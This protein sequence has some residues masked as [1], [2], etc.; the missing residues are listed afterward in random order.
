MNTFSSDTNQALAVYLLGLADDKLV[1]GHRNGE[2]TGLGPFLEA[3]IAF[4]NIAQDEVAHAQEVYRLVADLTEPDADRTVAA[5][6]LAYDRSSQQ[7]YCANILVKSDDFDWATA[8]CRQ[9]MFDHF[10]HVRLPALADSTYQPLAGLAAKMLQEVTFHIEHFDDWVVRLG[11][12]ND[13]S[14]QRM[15][16]AMASLWPEMCGLFTETSGQSDLMASG[17]VPIPETAMAAWFDILA[18][19]FARADLKLPP[20]QPVEDTGRSG[21]YDKVLQELLD[22]LGEVYHTDPE[23]A[24]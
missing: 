1:L 22:E 23:A 19:V 7:R 10:D 2:W 5:N 12:G 21:R 24:W 11:S 6:R 4:S 3:D 9:C 18:D 15:Q 16:A 14:R 13:E 20:A 17:I 8:V